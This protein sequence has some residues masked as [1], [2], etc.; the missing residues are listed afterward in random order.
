LIL[1]AGPIGLALVEV[2]RAKGAKVV[3]TDIAAERLKTAADLG[4]TPLPA[5]DG[6][7]D[8]VM[9]LTN[10][11]GMP[12]VIE[13]TGNAKAMESTVDLVAAGGRIVIVGLVRKGTML[14]LPG[15]DFTRKEMTIVGSRASVGCFPESL[16]LIARGAIRYPEI[17]SAFALSEAPRV[18]GTLAENPSALHKAVFVK[19][20]A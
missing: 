3:I 16:D 11:E 5:G 9:R 8:E 15:L 6:L 7:L 18:F 1:G 20:S 13:A 12:V 10:G 14:S 4:A 2:A 19:E 17:A